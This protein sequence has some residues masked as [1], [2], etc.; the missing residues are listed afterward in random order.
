MDEDEKTTERRRAEA[1]QWFARLKTLPVSHGT[2][3]DFFAWRQQK[4]N[5]DAFVEAERFWNETERVGDRPAIM[6]AIAAAEGRKVIPRRRRAFF[7]VPAFAMLVAAIAVGSMLVL[8]GRTI[9][10]TEKGEVRAVALDDGSRVHLDTET[11]IKL[12][13]RADSRQLTL[14]HGEALFRVAHDVSRPFIVTAGDVTVTATGTQ[15]D[16]SCFDDN[17]SV[18]LMQ[19]QVVVR[20]PDGVSVTLSPGQ[21]WLW[22]QR[23]QPIR[24]VNT[25]NVVAWTQGRV[26]FDDTAL[27]DA[28]ATVNRYGGKPIALDDPVMASERISGTFEAGDSQSFVAAVT[29]FLPLRQHDDASGRIHLAAR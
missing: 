25:G 15:F 23:G 24:T 12:R 22:P 3:R 27:A 17:I 10:Q 1:A 4:S 28:I 9:L 18:T 16:V 2:L 11:R 20:A 6:R 5:A 8:Q 19:G 26:V 13:Y 21:Q 29:A 14:Q 7:V